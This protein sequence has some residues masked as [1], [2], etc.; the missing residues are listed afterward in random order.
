MKPIQNSLFALTAAVIAHALTTGEI[1]AHSQ[2]YTP[3]LTTALV[4]PYLAIQKSL[5]EDDLEGA[6]KGANDFL[7]AMKKAP[8]TGD[9]KEETDALMAPATS[10]AN[11]SDIAASRTAFQ[12]LTQEVATLIKHMGTTRNTPLYLIHCP[13]AFNNKGADWVQADKT[14]ANPYFGAS[15][16]RCGS[17]KAEMSAEGTHTGKSTGLHDAHH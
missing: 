12:Q 9:A 7:E 16:L 8:T 6:K 2:E 14:V 10:L 4:E 11:A 5:A 15:M 17:I 3:E 13:M 1:M